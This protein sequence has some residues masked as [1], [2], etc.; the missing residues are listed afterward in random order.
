M[1]GKIVKDWSKVDFSNPEHC[2]HLVGAMNFFF[3]KPD[4]DVTLRGAIQSFATK[5][6]F[7]DEIRQVIEKFHAT[8]DWDL[9]YEAIFDIRDFQSSNVGGFDLLNVESGLQFTKI[10]TGGQ[11]EIQKMSGTKVTVPFDMY[12]GGLGLHRT[13]M[14][15]RQYWAIEDT[16]IEFRNKAY[17][18]RSAAFYALIE[19]I[20][21]SQNIAWQA[22]DGSIPATSSDYVAIRDSNTINK[23]AESIILGLKDSGLGVT[24]ASPLIL[25]APLQ[26]RGRI[27]RAMQWANQAFAGSP[28][29]VNYNIQVIFTMMLTSATTYYVCLPKKKAK[30]GYRMDLTVYS[31]F[32]MLTYADAMAGWIRYG[33][34]IGELGQFRRCAVS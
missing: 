6:D 10:P 25:L 14:D 23:A 30:G 18:G 22:V 20:S 2:R 31:Q 1:K 29:R 19:A 3:Q 32:D 9:G 33:G 8:P 17:S 28:M 4:K 24:P 27:E 26:L 34:A 7:P 16:M 15:D 11:I 5:G 13:L 21:S 12:G